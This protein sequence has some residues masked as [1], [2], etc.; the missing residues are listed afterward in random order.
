MLQRLKIDSQ[1]M[2]VVGDFSLYMTSIVWMKS[3][4]SLKRRVC[5][6]EMRLSARKLRFPNVRVSLALLKNDQTF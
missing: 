3:L 2:I 5:L 1:S 6:T 4:S